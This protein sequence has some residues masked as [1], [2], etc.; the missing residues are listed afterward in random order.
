MKG[1]V[2]K[3][4]KNI[5][6]V[7]IIILLAMIGFAIQIVALSKS[8]NYEKDEKKL[9]F[10]HGNIDFVSNRTDKSNEL[11]ELVDEF[12]KIY[13]NVHV[14]LELIGDVEEILERKAAVGDLP[15]VTLVPASINKREFS[16][17]FLP[18]DDLGFNGDNMYDYVSG[19]GSDNLLYTMP[20]SSLWH[21]VIYNKEIFNNLGIDTYPKTEE[22]FFKVCSKIKNNGIVPIALNYRQSWMMNTW[23][24]TIPYLYNVHMEDKLI[25]ESKDVFSS[26]GEI[27]KSLNFVK[28]IYTS[29][30]CESD[31]VNYDWAQCKEDIINGKTAMIIWNS[32]FINQLV[33]LG[34]DKNDLG[35]FPIPET[36]VINMI[37]DYR[38]G[39]SKNTKYPEASKAFLKFLFEEDRYANA[40]DIMS[41]LRDSEENLKMIDE[42]NKFN[43]PVVFQEN[44]AAQNDEESKLHDK[45]TYLRKSIGLDY[46]F[47]Q[48]YITS[49]DTK[50]IEKEAN[51]KWRLYRDKE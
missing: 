14:N 28:K 16:S 43:I 51:D 9:N 32:D 17:Y 35:M 1:E 27:Y 11:N 13:P 45:Y 50:K 36:N 49:E 39:I 15:D 5:K 26:D 12:E 41:S 7:W 31:I 29:G 18:I 2:I 19:L 6:R 8:F 23:I 25:G 48:N 44:I 37:G 3:V 46:T 33:D 42:L 40:V 4:L 21:G 20:T 34:M 47:I 10:L 24:D 38:I 22:E 30:Y